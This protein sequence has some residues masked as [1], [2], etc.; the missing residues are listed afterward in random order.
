MQPNYQGQPYPPGAQFQGQPGYYGAPQPGYGQPPAPQYGQPVPTPQPTPGANLPAGDFSDPRG[1]GGALAPRIRHMAGN[2]QASPPTRGRTV[3]I[4]PIRIDENA[5]GIP[6]PDGTVPINPCAYV[7]LT[8]VDG[9]PIEFG[10]EW[11]SSRQIKPNTHR[12][13]T[14]YRIENMMI[15][16]TY[17][18]NSIRD[19]MPPLGNGLLLGIIETGTQ[20]NNPYLLTKC[21]IDVT[22]G[23]RPDGAQRREAA[24]QLW[25]R[26][27]GGAFVNPVP[28]PL[29]P[30]QTYDPASYATQGTP[31]YQQ[32]PTYAPQAQYGGPVQPGYVPTPPYVQPGMTP[33]YAHQPIQPQT[34]GMVNAAAPMPASAPPA[35]APGNGLPPG[36]DVTQ[37]PP[38]WDA[39]QWQGFA[40]KPAQA[41]AIWANAFAQQGQQAMAAGQVPPSNAGIAQQAGQPPPW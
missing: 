17:I 13:D 14:P 35:T 37:C 27:K 41:A 9:G 4:E 36:F 39:G 21:E 2:V 31:A 7:N 25:Q 40:D 15:G 3:I 28:V 24:R 26:I 5:K 11:K 10:D 29:V 18:V 1:G 8:I 16:N 12:V 33:A 23:D 6:R 20:G 34:A 38:G 22:G 19:A 30:Q 32:P